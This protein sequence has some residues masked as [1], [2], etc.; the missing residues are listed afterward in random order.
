[1]YNFSMWVQESIYSCP[2]LQE[3]KFYHLRANFADLGF[4][5]ECQGNRPH[6]KVN[7]CFVIAIYV[8][9]SLGS[10][11]PCSTQSISLFSRG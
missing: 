1:M 6:G 9:N 3:L 5:E 7:K 4:G 8:K 10:V 2:K 11:P